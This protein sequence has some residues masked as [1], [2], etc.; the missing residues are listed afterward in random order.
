M[1]ACFVSILF[2]FCGI[3]YGEELAD[4]DAFQQKL[5]GNLV[6]VQTIQG[7][8]TQTRE[9]PALEMKLEFTGRLAYDAPARRLLWRVATPLPCAFRMQAGELSQWDGE[10]GKVMSIP[11]TKL[12]WIQLLQER[13]GQWLSGDLPALR[14]EAEV[15]V[16]SAN[17]VRLIPTSGLLVTLAKRVEI[18]FSSDLTRVAQILIEEKTGDRLTI[19]FHNTVLNQPIPEKTW[20]LQ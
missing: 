1:I 9:L 4:V 2:V 13:L 12:P 20:D 14:K 18:E 6:A 8:F 5:A 11:A 19:R 15:E 10:T 17:K 16:L 7:E 3:A